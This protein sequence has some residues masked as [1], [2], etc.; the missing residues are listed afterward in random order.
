MIQI[1]LGILIHAVYQNLVIIN[2]FD[3]FVVLA[4]RFVD[5]D[6]KHRASEQI[7]TPSQYVIVNVDLNCVFCLPTITTDK[8]KH[9]DRNYAKEYAV[10]DA[11]P[12][13]L[14]KSIGRLN[15]FFSCIVGK[16]PAEALTFALNTPLNCRSI[17]TA[18]LIIY[19]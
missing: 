5:G 1:Y 8:T 3:I 15:G 18:N 19:F 11:G 6:S 14:G 10:G 4:E 17:P 16:L 2:C 13:D 12:S 9:R 7:D